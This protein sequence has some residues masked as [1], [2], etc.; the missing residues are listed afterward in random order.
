[1]WFT[2]LFVSLALPS[3]DD[4]QPPETLLDQ[5]IAEVGRLESCDV[6]YTLEVRDLVPVPRSASG[7]TMS[8][9]EAE[10]LRQAYQ[11]RKE[12]A[13]T[14][15]TALRSES[16][17][18]T[19]TSRAEIHLVRRR[20]DFLAVIKRDE[21]DRVMSS[22]LDASRTYVLGRLGSHTTRYISKRDYKNAP[23]VAPP[24]ERVPSATLGEAM[25][26]DGIGGAGKE[27]NPLQA[28]DLILSSRWA[29][30]WVVPLPPNEPPYRITHKREASPGLRSGQLGVRSKLEDDRLPQNHSSRLLVFELDKCPMPKRIELELT[31]ARYVWH[32]GWHRFGTSD[33]DTWFPAEVRRESYYL[34]EGVN[35]GK[36]FHVETVKVDLSRSR[37]NDSITDAELTFQL[38]V[39]TIVND[40]RTGE[41][42]AVT[43]AGEKGEILL[44]QLLSASELPSPSWTGR[45][46]LI[47]I[48]VNGVV[49]SAVILLVVRFRRRT[50][51]P[52][53]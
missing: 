27:L 52:P 10:K 48:L 8:N 17:P 47:I 13:R 26:I 41:K 46:T 18:A 34:Q 39:G 32:V 40:L 35:R 22:E 28:F 7:M 36:L 11:D 21:P 43:A 16:D 42:Y 23:A 53:V 50:R 6:W 9:E 14:D 24:A 25:S 45:R 2:L 29:P 33:G 49:L 37:V 19:L 51:T 5:A 3:A 12:R 38:P 15:P 4:A 44:D 20:E 1:M 31:D 30:M